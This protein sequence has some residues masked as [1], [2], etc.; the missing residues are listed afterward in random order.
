M[1]LTALS[2]RWIS[3]SLDMEKRAARAPG[4]IETTLRGSGLWLIPDEPNLL[5]G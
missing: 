4:A 2:H 3:V 1:R 5:R